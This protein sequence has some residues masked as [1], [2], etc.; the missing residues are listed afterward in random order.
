PPGPYGLGTTVVTLTVTDSLGA[1]STS[2][3]TVTVVDTTAPT[4][5]CPANPVVAATSSAGA[6]VAD[7][8]PTATDNC[9]A[10]RVT[11]APAS[12]VAFAIG[13]TPVQCTA[14]DQGNNQ[15]ACTFTVKVKSAAKQTTDL[16]AL[17]TSD[18]LASGTATS[19]LAKLQAD[20]TALQGND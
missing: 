5:V 6:V 20:L 14:T 12:G 1:S 10:V 9:P 11:C 4:I 15:A 19:L 3:A 18:Q 16:M 7:P 13:I 8:A 2:Q 17:V